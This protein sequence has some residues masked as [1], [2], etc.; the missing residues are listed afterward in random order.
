[1]AAVKSP[2]RCSSDRLSRWSKCKCLS[3]G[4]REDA[5]SIAF[6]IST[7]HRLHFI[8]Y[9]YSTRLIDSFDVCLQARSIEKTLQKPGST[10]LSLIA[11][12]FALPVRLTG[13]VR[14]TCAYQMRPVGRA[15]RPCRAVFRGIRMDIT[16]MLS[17]PECKSY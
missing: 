4:R 10:L 8:V 11:M 9:T 5:H 1:M 6:L 14:P 7:L 3:V 2:V 13:T 15:R 12:R 17:R 16:V